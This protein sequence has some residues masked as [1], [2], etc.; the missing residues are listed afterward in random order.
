MTTSHATYLETAFLQLSFAVK[1]RHYIDEHPI[2]K[3]QFDISLT[4][5]DADDRICL[6]HNEF[7]S[8]EDLLLAADNN[9][10]ICFGVAAISLWLAIEEKGHYLPKSLPNPL[11]TTQHKLAGLIYMIRCCFA[12][13]TAVP[14]WNITHDKYKIVYDIGSQQ[15]DLRTV[16]GEP[17]TRESIGGYQTLWLLRR[18]AI[19]NNML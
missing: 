10:S 7:K 5:E 19:S 4:V 15:V 13:G 9:I 17:F 12:H 11:Q 8:Q 3:G 16:H 14:K 2:D 18:E 1:L 6:P